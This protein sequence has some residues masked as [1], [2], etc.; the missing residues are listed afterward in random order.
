MD[1]TKFKKVVEGAL[2]LSRL[3]ST[4]QRLSRGQS[5][6]CKHNFHRFRKMNGADFGIFFQYR[7]HLTQDQTL[8]NRDKGSVFPFEKPCKFYIEKH[9]EMSHILS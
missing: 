8:G 9:L 6:N 4:A 7:Q 1:T 3:R 2:T 5:N